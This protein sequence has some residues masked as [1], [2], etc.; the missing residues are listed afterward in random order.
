[1]G[2]I[3]LQ[4][5]PCQFNRHTVK[6]IISPTDIIR[7]P[8]DDPKSRWGISVSIHTIRRYEH[9][10]L[11]LAVMIKTKWANSCVYGYNPNMLVKKFGI[12][13]N[14]INKYIEYL[15]ENKLAYMRGTTLCIGRL[16]GDRWD[17]IQCGGTMKEIVFQFRK[18]FIDNNIQSQVDQI[19]RKDQILSTKTKP[20][21]AK[22][23][24]RVKEYEKKHG[25][26]SSKSIDRTVRVTINTICRLIGISR[27]DAVRLRK[28]LI[29]IG[30]GF[31][32]ETRLVAP[33][34][35]FPVHSL[36][37][38]MYIHRG[39]VMVRDSWIAIPINATTQ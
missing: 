10:P 1:M 22:D 38:F 13:R 15:I 23:I 5:Y 25:E 32:Y 37:T 8:P 29:D 2:E 6:N 14:T 27:R 18:S 20:S 19:K 3:K 36:N 35:F 33:A 30:Y 24:R 21:S 31:N 11:A 7:E 34:K 17:N 12:S 16:K 28:Q 4:E 26:I 39:N 9:K